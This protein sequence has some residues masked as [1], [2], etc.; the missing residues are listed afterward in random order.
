MPITNNESPDYKY[1]KKY[2]QIKEI[3]KQYKVLEYYYELLKV[4]KSL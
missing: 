3:E 4:H 1:M 2:M